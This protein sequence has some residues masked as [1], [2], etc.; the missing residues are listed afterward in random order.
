MEV[1][2]RVACHA[3]A[4]DQAVFVTTNLEKYTSYEDAIKSSIYLNE[5]SNVT[6]DF[7]GSRTVTSKLQA[8]K[9][10]EDSNF[11]YEKFGFISK[12]DL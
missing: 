8:P 3:T 12:L 10:T 11:W 2:R 1:E 7:I 6:T 4:I 9:H 5:C